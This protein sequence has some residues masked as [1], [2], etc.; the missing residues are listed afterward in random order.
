[1]HFRFNTAFWVENQIENILYLEVVYLYY[2]SFI[3]YELQY[4]VSHSYWGNLI[5][6]ETF[7]EFHF[8][9][10]A[11]PAFLRFWSI[12]TIFDLVLNM[13]FNVWMNLK[14][15]VFFCMILIWFFVVLTKFC[16]HHTILMCLLTNMT[17]LY[18]LYVFTV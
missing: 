3:W 8:R 2:S 16:G 10:F 11:T 5:L 1:M 9:N 17:F 14:H 6:F 4:I 18:T 7:A 15:V 12:E 13:V